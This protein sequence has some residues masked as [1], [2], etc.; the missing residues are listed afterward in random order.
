MP[1]GPSIVILKES[2]QQF[3]GKKVIAVD[4]NAKI[5]LQRIKNKTIK[6]F[7]S[8]GKHFLICF[9]DFYLRVHFLMFGSYRIDEEKNTAP[10][11]SLKFKKGV[12]NF[13]TCSVRMEEG[14]V[15]AIY[16]FSIDVMSE[17]WSPKRILKKLESHPDDLVSDALLN[18]ELFAGV[19]NIIKNEVLYRIKIHPESKV[20][21]LP[22]EKLEEMVLEASNYSFDFYEWKKVYELRKNWLCYKKQIC[23]RDN[24][25]FHRGKIGKT[26]RL[27]FY[28]NNCQILYLPAEKQVKS[29]RQKKKTI[30]KKD[31]VVEIVSKRKSRNKLSVGS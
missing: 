7:R 23:R 12:L 6:D 1:E 10:R 16:D 28:C 22:A 19:G 29:D 13:Y 4:G 30:K 21:S 5:D 14:S 27:T 25:K 9:D 18:Q 24:V 11:L 15:D 31:R 20:G 8:W 3:K 17:M 26:P 2:V